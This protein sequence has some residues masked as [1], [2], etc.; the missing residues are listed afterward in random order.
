MTIGGL[1]ASGL[2]SATASTNTAYGIYSLSSTSALQITGS[3]NGKI[4]A[5]AQNG[6]TAS[7]IR[8]LS[9]LSIGGEIAAGAE[10]TATQYSGASNASNGATGLYSAKDLS[11]T[12]ALNGKVSATS[13]SGGFAYG[14]YGGA[15]TTNTLTITG[16][17]GTTGIVTATANNSSIITDSNV[18]GIYSAGN[19]TI[20]AD[21]NKAGINGQVSADAGYDTAYGIY[22][23]TVTI[24]GDIGPYFAPAGAT[25]ASGLISASAGRNSAYGI[26]S[27]SA[28]AQLKIDGS[29][30]GQIIATAGG[31]T[32]YGIYSA[33]TVTGSAPG[34]EITGS[35]N[36]KI[37]AQATTG[38]TAGGIRS[39][40][41][42]SIGG[43]IA[44]GAEITA[45]QYSGATN[46]VTGATGLYSAKDL[47]IT[48]ALNGKVS[49]TS[50][51]GGYAFGIYGGASNNTLTITG[52]I[53]TT[54]IV[55]A[56]ANNSTN[57]NDSNVSGIYFAGNVT[58]GADTNKA[59]I[60]GQVSADAGYDTAYGI[61]GNTVTIY[62]DIG[63][64]VAPAGATPASGLIS[65]TAGRNGAYGIY[66]ALTTA[67]MKIDGSI[68]G[69][70]IATAVGSTA[71]GIYSASTSAS[72]PGVEI[73]GSINGKISAEARTGSA[74]YGIR[75]QSGLS[76]KG[77]IG[78]NVMAT[79]GTFGAYGI[80]ALTTLDV[81]GDISGD[82][83]AFANTGTTAYALHSGTAL[84]ITGNL[85]SSFTTETQ[86]DNT[87]KIL[88]YGIY[89]K[90]GTTDA[91]AIDA[92]GDLTIK[93]NLTGDVTAT[94]NGSGAYG[95][96]SGAALAIRGSITSSSVISATGSS[97][98]YG[99][100]S[101]GNLT[102]GNTLDNSGGTI[103]G[104]IFAKAT[105]GGS[106]YGISGGSAN[107]TFLNLVGGMGVGGR[108]TAIAPNTTN[109]GQVYG[110]YSG[111][112]IIIDHSGGNTG[113]SGVISATTGYSHASGIE[114]EA[115]TIYG[116]IK[117]TGS[118][119]ASASNAAYGIISS[120]GSDTFDYEPYDVI[121]GEN[122]NSAGIS[123]FISA[124]ATGDMAYG[125]AAESDRITING[126]IGD[127]NP[128]THAGS[129]SAVAGGNQAFAIGIRYVDAQYYLQH[130]AYVIING[131]IKGK[132][133]ASAG[134]IESMGIYSAFGTTIN[135]DISESAVITAIANGGSGSEMFHGWGY[136]SAI[137]I[138]SSHGF[139]SING[140]LLGDI[141]ATAYN[142]YTASGIIVGAG[143]SD[144]LPWTDQGP[145][146]YGNG[147]L[148][149]TG[150]IGEH[151]LIHAS[152]GGATGLSMSI[153][154]IRG[155]L[156]GD[157]EVSGGDVTGLDAHDTIDIQ[158]DFAESASISALGTDWIGAGMSSRVIKIG[159]ALD[160]DISAQAGRNA[161]G[162]H[163]SST[164]G[165]DPS[166]T[167]TGGIGE[168]SRI[169]VTGLAYSGIV[170]SYDRFGGIHSDGTIV[171]GHEGIATGVNGSI[172]VTAVGVQAA[173][174]IYGGGDVTIYGDIARYDST[175]GTGRYSA[176][177]SGTGTAYGIIA[178]GAG[179][180]GILTINGNIRGQVYSEGGGAAYG[181][182]SLGSGGLR[183]N[184][185]ISD[186]AII[187]ANAH[188]RTAYGLFSRFGS[189]TWNGEMSE[190]TQVI[191]SAVLGNSY[192]IYGQNMVVTG[193][194]NGTVSASSSSA[195]TV[196]G[197]CGYDYYNGSMYQKIFANVLNIEGGISSTGIV[198]A[199][200]V[201]SS[202]NNVKNVFGFF[203]LGSI[204]I[205]HSGGTTGIDGIIS[206]T[207]GYDSAYGIRAGNTAEG[208][209]SWD[210]S[211]CYSP[212]NIYGGIGEFGMISA[213]AGR[214]NAYALSA[215]SMLTLSGDISGD[216]S[217]TATTGNYAYAMHAGHILSISGNIT[218]S[219]LIT[220]S[221]GASYAYGL[222]AGDNYGYREE[223]DILITGSIAGDVSATAVT[224]SVAY[225][226]YAR[227]NL[228]ITG[229]I[230]ELSQIIATAGTSNAIAFYARNGYLSIGG[231]VS[232]SMT[233]TATNGANAAGLYAENGG[234]F[235]ITVNEPMQI[236]GTISATAKGAVAGI[237][238]KG[239]MNLLISGEIS[240]ID[241]SGTGLGY[242]ILSGSFNNAGGFLTSGTS[243]DVVTVIGAGRLGGNIDLGAGD[244]AL[245]M[246]DSAHVSGDIYMGDGNDRI[247]LIQTLA[248]T[249][250][251]GSTDSSVNTIRSTIRFGAGDDR[252]SIQNNLSTKM[253]IVGLSGVYFEAGN[254]TVTL[255]PNI[256]T[257]SLGV[258]SGGD[259]NDTIE[260]AGWTGEITPNFKDWE[261]V[262]VVQ[263]SLAILNLDQ[264]NGLK[265]SSGQELNV[266]IDAGSMVR[267]VGHSPGRYTIHGNLTNNGTVSLVDNGADDRVTV[268]GNYVGGTGYLRLDV[269]LGDDH[270]MGS[271]NLDALDLLV[272]GTAAG[273]T[274]LRVNNT[275]LLHK[276]S[277][278]PASTGILV[279]QV[280]GSNIVDSLDPAKKQ[281]VLDKS[282]F[283]SGTQI[284]VVKVGE[285]WYLVVTNEGES[286]PD[287]GDKV[288]D[289]G[290]TV[291]DPGD[292]VPII[293]Y[294]SPVP[295]PAEQQV[296]VASVFGVMA[297]GYES[298]PRFHERQ[299]YG[300]S[301]P[302]QARE[303]A[304]WWMRTTG[305]RYTSGLESGGVEVRASGYR[306][307]MQV[308]ADLSACG[309]GGT[310]YRMGVFAGTGYLSADS[311]GSNGAKA[312]HTDVFSMGVGGYASV[313]H[314]GR[315]YA[316]GVVQANTY[317]ISSSFTGNTVKSGAGTWSY[318]ASV[319]AG[320]YVK[321][322][323]GFRLEPQA[324]VMW[325]RIAG[326][327]MRIDPASMA[328]V[329]SMTG[330][331]GRLGV[332]GTVMP[333]GWCVSPIVELNAVR[334]FGDDAKV[335]WEQ[336][337]Q[338][339]SVKTD[340]TWL[341]GALGIVSRNSRPDCL[342][343]FVKAGLM[344]G[345]DGHNGRDW[346]ITAG[347]RKS[348]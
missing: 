309:C 301:A 329:S 78:G 52:G 43:G 251:F 154:T 146:P 269:A 144:E 316:E 231:I 6:N 346:T 4:S 175:E 71:Y 96:C 317:D 22:G 24:Y 123:G 340:R 172:M 176:I 240:G 254:D 168:K 80:H 136:S 55:T 131:D 3:I 30:D 68:D 298:M 2:I 261:T 320:A 290:D 15:A 313:E 110:L 92:T 233:A 338:T 201:N 277:L 243:A 109:G 242:S 204:T 130:T 260:L 345:V 319:E 328:N 85:V 101:F 174:T 59:G 10:I 34:I 192:G 203:T 135:G 293:T 8:S 262:R 11:I 31:G 311:Y 249:P 285:D 118:I 58:I 102:L 79:A 253:S 207:A 147:E 307:T 133:Y 163:A 39:M 143:S 17:I 222:T 326:Y 113:I 54:G 181:F 259:G 117:A 69:Q 344:A 107:S 140:S 48:G 263:E 295:P 124:V 152:G 125:I 139:L 247:T 74:A 64:Y 82:I 258:I 339:Y 211:L 287:P 342:E 306:S 33:S 7:G 1:G 9:G 294:P 279:V 42:L 190:E 276:V 199:R 322:S 348:W 95:F 164:L 70:I 209:G 116:G 268:T 37:S 246:S 218:G 61:Y 332:T 156:K 46:A 284:D 160:G 128:D 337:G 327:S 289:P 129:V 341:G 281:F 235:G 282:N 324:Q 13:T 150:D 315:W 208:M 245:D 230:S 186:K 170:D 177:S 250:W 127:Y 244:D 308:G 183:I 184:G 283:T 155:S 221:A 334:E 314:R 120:R 26:Y 182:G 99:L 171:I 238:A 229:N 28:T 347:I 256:D 195:G 65:A 115:L 297:L 228:S 267:A 137:G 49:A 84:T 206:A 151:A 145:Y 91:R 239:A 304:S 32:A 12:G 217:A 90:T 161:Y 225:G 223:G 266:Y 198:T 257:P 126:G 189:L 94:A 274:T 157:I 119:S 153:L 197:I 325:Q 66:S 159:G 50:T 88:T 169:M 134:G 252:L 87:L 162:L 47:M 93:G 310:L 224:G 216:I 321:V 14:I 158:G 73:T 318:A 103:Y 236:S 72:A 132:I 173:E 60:N 191:S 234:I 305:S 16:G 20:G 286:V 336:I 104:E 303:P 166:I 149:I 44:S 272:V 77:S 333:K 45:T 18:Y 62:G 213:I 81:T 255:G 205:G 264:I 67:Q 142:G 83:S 106:A 89:A 214:N 296:V 270:I 237:L 302:G 226:M 138:C 273:Q 280:T 291:P 112:K 122:R 38:S 178:G 212:V 19:V 265:P 232:G 330:L 27:A 114:A 5:E 185:N 63:S 275:S 40:G 196:I 300:W 180:T 111:G 36:G 179:G 165:S 35:I 97:S 86:P 29:I 202:T 188:G 312:G 323:E 288:P 331:Q 75:S 200:A 141:T 98:A 57:Y 108:V 167:L 100:Y 215:T 23:N 41:G 187:T 278:T 25:P 21:T 194:L 148:L 210:T 292:T 271:S 335:N 241:T 220:S 51:N 248:G 56:T 76:I 343:Y 53:G 193:A 121:I 299:A 219:A 105:T 227:R